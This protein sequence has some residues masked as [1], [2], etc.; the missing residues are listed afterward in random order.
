MRA[1][2]GRSAS[3]AGACPN[4]RA[5]PL[6][7]GARIG[8]SRPQEVMMRGSLLLCCV[9]WLLAAGCQGNQGSNP[10]PN[11]AP[12]QAPNQV[13]DQPAGQPADQPAVPAGI[14]PEYAAAVADICFGQ[15]RSGALEQDESQRAMVVAQ[16]LGTRIRTQQGRDFLASLAPA[17]PGQK[18]ALLQTESRKVGLSECPLMVSWGGSTP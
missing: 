14:D 7:P 9:V 11:E 1:G 8:Q 17:D 6:D 13:S 12:G 2:G 4:V 5:H 15:E 3:R 16:W 10:A 18:V